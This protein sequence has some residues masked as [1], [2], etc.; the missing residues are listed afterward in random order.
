[1]GT[2]WR[3]RQILVRTVAINIS[4][5]KQAESVPLAF[6]PNVLALEKYLNIVET[7]IIFWEEVILNAKDVLIAAV[8][9]EIKVAL[10]IEMF[11]IE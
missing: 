7:K 2:K 3:D 8:P 4:L 6:V 11:V 9:E 10:S 1:M 5:L